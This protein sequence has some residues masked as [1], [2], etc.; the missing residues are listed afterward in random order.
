MLSDD[1][2]KIPDL[3]NITIGNVKKLV[4]NFFWQRKIC[5]L[6][7]KL[8][9]L[10]KIRAEAKK[11]HHVLEFTK[12]IYWIKHTKKNRSRKNR[13]KD[14]KALHKLVIN[15]VYRK[16]M[17]NLRN[18]IDVKLVSKKKDYLKWTSKWSYM[19]HKIFDNDLMRD[20]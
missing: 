8:A 18:R 3:Y 15:A 11:I 14:G 20:M 13:D 17:E 2:L 5:D 19:S 6:W 4:P 10:L 12:K 9:T 1:H 7:W 16:I